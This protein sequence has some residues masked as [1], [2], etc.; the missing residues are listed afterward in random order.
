MLENWR[1]GRAIEANISQKKPDRSLFLQEEYKTQLA[2]AKL[3]VHENISPSDI[4]HVGT[5]LMA[6]ELIE[7]LR[8]PYA[9]EILGI[10]HA[11]K[12]TMINRYLQEMWLRDERHKIGFIPEG[13]EE[14]KKD[15]GDL[16]YSD[17]FLY[18]MLAS[19]RTFTGYI[20]ALKNVNSGM[21]M[22]VSDRGQIDR[23]VWRRALFS[24]GKVNPGLMEEEDEFIYGLEN[25]PLQIG[26][27]IMFM[28]RPEVSI[29]RDG[30]NKIGP[31]TNRDFLSRLHEQYWRLHQNILDGEIPYRIYTCIDAEQPAD[32]V[33]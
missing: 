4:P 17:P 8:V 5:L 33:Y 13:A 19:N 23:R 30:E 15:H 27:V 26:G 20:S 25:T 3:G 7:N 1:F 2:L 24:Q 9:V 12:T 28:V 18:S 14:I 11:G 31:V 32:E 21:T 29:T 22:A 6:P 10:P 16:R